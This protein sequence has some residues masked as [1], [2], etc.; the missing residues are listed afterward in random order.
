MNK[1][2]T[3]LFDWMSAPKPGDI[4]RNH[5]ANG[6]LREHL[7]E[8]NSL[9]GIPQSPQWHPEVDTG[10]HIEMCMDVVGKLT[11]DPAVRFAVLVHDLGKALTAVE[12]LPK[13]HGH[14][15]AGLP[16]VT[17]VCDRFDVPL[18][19][20]RLANLNCEHH[21]QVHRLAELRP[22][23]LVSW[24][25][26][27]DVGMDDIMMEGLGLA[28]QADKQGRLGLETQP[29][30]Q[31]DLLRGVAKVYQT[32]TRQGRDHQELCVEVADV[33][34]AHA[35]HVDIQNTTQFLHRTFA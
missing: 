17:A 8:V 16:A 31:R 28:C 29:Y 24:L 30:P 22:G 2:T 25:R 12:L 3:S 35:Y 20:R 32:G 13:H 14:E 18:F 10:I 15:L 21:I 34:K 5:R 6:W 11:D 27:T 23:T 19:W 9:Y 7:P 33:L 1:P 4:L 26:D